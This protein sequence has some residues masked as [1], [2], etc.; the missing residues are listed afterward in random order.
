MGPTERV[1]SIG[2]EGGVN[3]EER[4]GAN[5]RKGLASED[6]QAW[7]ETPRASQ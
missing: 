5:R 6:Y 7:D 1:E 3:G 4:S 2:G